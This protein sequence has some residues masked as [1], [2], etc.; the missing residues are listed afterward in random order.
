MCKYINKQ[1]TLIYNNNFHHRRLSFLLI[2]WYLAIHFLW[3]L[4]ILSTT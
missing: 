3:K 2:Y 4:F 1:S